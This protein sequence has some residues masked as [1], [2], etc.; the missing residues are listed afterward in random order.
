MSPEKVTRIGGLEHLFQEKRQ[1][2]LKLFSMKRRLWGHLTAVLQYIKT[3]Y[4]KAGKELFIKSIVIR[5]G[6]CVLNL[7]L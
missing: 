3:A 4:R 1:T 5:Q 2:G 6:V 7:K